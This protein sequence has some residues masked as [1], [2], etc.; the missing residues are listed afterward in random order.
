MLKAIF[1]AAVVAAAALPASAATMKATYTGSVGTPD[2]SAS[3]GYDV[4]GLFIGPETSF[5]GQDFTLTY[6]YDTDRGLGYSDPTT[7]QIYGG[8]AYAI[9]SPISYVSL[10]INGRTHTFGGNYSSYVQVNGH[11]SLD[12]DFYY[13]YAE[14]NDEAVVD[15]AYMYA[16]SDLNLPFG[17]RLID[18]IEIDLTDNAYCPIC[19]SNC[20]F[21]F[22]T[23]NDLVGY[24]VVDAYGSLS[25]THLSITRVTDSPDPSA[26]PLPAAFGPLLLALAGLGGL[27][28]GRRRL[29]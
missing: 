4:A 9:E 14:S 3:Y 29:G 22:S 27:R 2:G 10:K 25:A 12:N 28:A 24:N 13:H 7:D 5:S 21:Q 8:T 23:F 15:F 16:Y 26:V 20:R 18:P 6:V 11:D 1:A 17:I 19:S